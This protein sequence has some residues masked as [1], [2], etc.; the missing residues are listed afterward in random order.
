MNKIS[1]V[2]FLYTL[3]NLQSVRIDVKLKENAKKLL[4]EQEYKIEEK[5]DGRYIIES[6]HVLTGSAAQ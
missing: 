4:L 5:G 6:K 1:N 2:D 3:K